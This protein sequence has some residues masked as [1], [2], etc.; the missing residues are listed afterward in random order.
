MAGAAGGWKAEALGV[1]GRCRRSDEKQDAAP[2]GGEEK[3]GQGHAGAGDHEES[4]RGAGSPKWG[5][6]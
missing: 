4:N 3:I 2:D 1:R 5:Q 6:A